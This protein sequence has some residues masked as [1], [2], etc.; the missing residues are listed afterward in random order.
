MG[1]LPLFIA[2]KMS[3]QAQKLDIGLS[4]IFDCGEDI[5]DASPVTLKYSK[6]SGETGTWTG[7]IYNTNF[8]K[9][10]TVENDLD[11]NGYWSVQGYVVQSG[12]TRHTTPDQF[13][14]LD[15]VA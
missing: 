12:Y 8:I 10:T 15:N 4:I 3:E 6:P 11:E 2:E 9:Y 7:A 5:S 13:E 1:P 14:V